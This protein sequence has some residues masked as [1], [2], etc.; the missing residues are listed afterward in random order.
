MIFTVPGLGMPI[1]GSDKS[2]GF[3]SFSHVITGDGFPV[4]LHA[5]EPSSPLVTTAY[6]GFLTILGNPD[7]AVAAED[8][9][10]VF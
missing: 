1:L 8:V 10:F 4:A 2:S 5:N 6:P 7:G 3:D 9:K